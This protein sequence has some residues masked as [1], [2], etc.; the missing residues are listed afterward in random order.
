MGRQKKRRLEKPL[1]NPIARKK[2][3]RSSRSPSPQLDAEGEGRSSAPLSS[4]EVDS[5]ASSGTDPLSNS[6][7]PPSPTMGTAGSAAGGQPEG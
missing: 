6:D 5:P 2:R 3:R 7:D 4:E 1:A